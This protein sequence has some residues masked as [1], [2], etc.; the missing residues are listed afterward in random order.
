[1]N[2]V[3]VALLVSLVAC[4]PDTPPPAID[5]SAHHATEA[6]FYHVVLRPV[7]G[8]TP[9]GKI[10]EW[11]VTVYD[12]DGG[13]VE[14]HSLSVDGGMP[15]HGHGLVTAPRVTKKLGPGKFLIEGVKFHMPGRWVFNL[16]IS[17]P[18]GRDLLRLELDVGP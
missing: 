14:P 10:H 16:G 7:D 8:E 17:G 3:A 18:L 1:M 2:A 6:G 11:E 4:S 13:P 5:W 9:V 15:Q 12:P